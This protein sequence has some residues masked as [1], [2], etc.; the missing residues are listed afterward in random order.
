MLFR[1]ILNCSES[2]LLTSPTHGE[3]L[4]L[5]NSLILWC[6]KQHEKLFSGKPGTSQRCH[7]LA[8]EITFDVV[9]LGHFLYISEKLA[10]GHKRFFFL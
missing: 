10:V 2:E 9:L 5:P 4:I 3:P 1:I 8:W 6:I 7:R